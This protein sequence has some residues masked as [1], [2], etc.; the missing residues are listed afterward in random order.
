[1]NDPSHPQ[2][3]NSTPEAN[4]AVIPQQASRT[5]RWLITMLVLVLTLILFAALFA[6]RESRQQVTAAGE[7]PPIAA[8]AM[9][10]QPRDI[11]RSLQAVGTLRAVRS[12]MLSTETAGRVVKI[13][14]EGGQTVA[15]DSLLVQL[16]DAPERADRAAAQ[17]RAQLSSA[18][19]KR[20]R[21][22]IDSGAESRENLDERRAEADQAAAIVTQ[23]E[24]RIEQKQVRA[25]FAGQLGIRRVDLGQYLQ[26]GDAIATLTD[27]SQLFVDFAIPQQQLRWLQPQAQVRITADAWP[28]REFTARVETIEPQVNAETRNITVRAVLD[29]PDNLLRAGMFVNAALQLPAQRDQLVVPTTAIQTSAAGDNLVVIRGEDPTTGGTAEF[30]RVTVA[31]RMGDL[32]VISS[33]VKIN[34]VVITEGQ[35]KL[36]PGARVQVKQLLPPVEI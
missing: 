11:P 36:S 25:P 20:S 29:N 1:M 10:L 28:E 32:A 24:A 34:D 14:F 12:V 35:L 4:A 13:E 3:A 16:Y 21:R 8:A 33:G 19:L 18:Q 30:V 26:P 17:A 9:R 5:R 2:S 6:W 31:R 27:T 23:M 22:L 7:R 15:A